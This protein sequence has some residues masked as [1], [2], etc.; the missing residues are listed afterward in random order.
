MGW[1]ACAAAESGGCEPPQPH[2]DPAP[3]RSAAIA[4]ERIVSIPPE[5]YTLPSGR[6]AARRR[7]E[8]SPAAAR[9]ALDGC[10]PVGADAGRAAHEEAE[11]K[12]HEPDRPRRG[13]R[14]PASR[15]SRRS[16]A[17]GNIDLDVRD[18]LDVGVHEDHAVN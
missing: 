14:P 1:A 11:G 10:M 15:R 17:A 16:A 9:D 6:A 18:R 8:L 12:E 7:A 13:A 4:N 5:S 2:E 3:A